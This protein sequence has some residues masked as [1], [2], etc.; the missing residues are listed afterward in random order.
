MEH[1]EEGVVNTVSSQTYHMLAIIFGV[2]ASLLVILSV[3][4]YLG[5]VP[6]TWVNS[7]SDTELG[8]LAV[9]AIFVAGFAAYEE[10]Q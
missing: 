9:L 1:G 8:V 10:K 2:I 7:L 3:G 6:T 4:V 5:Y